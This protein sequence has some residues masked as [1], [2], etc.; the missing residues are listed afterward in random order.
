MEK[1][2]DMLKHLIDKKINSEIEKF[3]KQLDRVY[4]EFRGNLLKTL[5][6][7]LNKTK[8]E[9]VQMNNNEMLLEEEFL[10]TLRIL[11][12]NSSKIESNDCIVIIAREFYSNLETFHDLSKRDM[13]IL[14]LSYDAVKTQK[15]KSRVTCFAR[16][17]GN[18]VQVVKRKK[19]FINKYNLL[20]GEE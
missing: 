15:N 6:N 14:L 20:E 9:I 1:E 8:L 19:D 11:L 17:N 2:H 12:I 4:Y 7:N 13:N 3:G 10:K 16:I 18:I 5:K